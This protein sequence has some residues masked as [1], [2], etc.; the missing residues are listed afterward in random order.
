A[1]R[2]ATPASA[3][4][5]EQASEDASDD[6]SEVGSLSLLVPAR[7][8]EANIGDCVAAL[9]GQ[10]ALEVLVLDDESTDATAARARAALA[11]T[12]ARGAV[13]AGRPLPPGWRGKSFACAQLAGA[14]SGDWL[15]F[16]DA[17]VRLA[18]GGAARALRQARDAGADLA[19]FFPRYTGEHWSNRVVVPWLYFFLTALLPV[20]EVL[21][22]RH[23]R[24]AAAIGQ[25]ILIRRDVYARFGG[26]ERVRERV[27][28]DVSLAIE[29]KRAG[30][31]VA[32]LDGHRWLECRMY[33][34]TRGL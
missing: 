11:A 7:N 24:L 33:A 19:S 23:P 5:P 26:H 15:F 25:A 28:E 21:R 4:R 10:G 32:L 12:G 13:L 8:E 2:G 22:T 9:A 34:S 17:D 1:E 16:L 29:A 30:L 14:A 31:R 20:P 3:Q 6:A 18:P 27:I